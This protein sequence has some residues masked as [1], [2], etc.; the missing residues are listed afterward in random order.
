MWK[1]ALNN[2]AQMLAQFK[3]NPVEFLAQRN[4]SLPQGINMNDPQA[5]INHLV[6]T[7]RFSQQQI[8]QAYSMMKQLGGK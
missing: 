3:S 5:V 1:A 6:S 2:P 7:G 4:I 8:N